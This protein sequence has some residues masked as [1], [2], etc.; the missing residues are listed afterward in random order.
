VGLRRAFEAL[1]G[2]P[3]A[4]AA[5]L[6]VVMG[7]ALIGAWPET[8]PG[9]IALDDLLQT[10]GA[11][12]LGVGTQGSRV[13][14]LALD[15]LASLPGVRIDEDRMISVDLAQPEARAALSEMAQAQRGLVEARLREHHAELTGESSSVSAEVAAREAFFAEATTRGSDPTTWT[16][17]HD[18]PFYL[19]S[20]EE[21]A[22]V[23]AREVDAERRL[24]AAREWTRNIVSL[25][26]GGR[27]QLILP[28]SSLERLTES[29]LG[30]L[31]AITDATAHRRGVVLLGDA[32]VA[33]VRTGGRAEELAAAP[34]ALGGE[35]ARVAIRE[36]LEIR[37]R[38]AGPT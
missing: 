2:V 17:L 9:P 23:L 38:R 21:I 37:R 29:Q 14:E 4:Q 24:Q 16:G 36:A 25:N 1:A 20:V 34:D 26:R 7:E 30:M 5:A 31:L 18:L 15:A 28:Y 10:C 3:R 19:D 11:G 12:S 6:L 13:A 27:E 33:E 32:Q 8:T 22:T 35:V